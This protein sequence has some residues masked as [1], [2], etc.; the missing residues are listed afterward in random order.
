MISHHEQ[1]IEM[2]E[3]AQDPARPAPRPEVL[4]RRC[5]G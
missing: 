5:P 2:A 3:I 4:D 1:A